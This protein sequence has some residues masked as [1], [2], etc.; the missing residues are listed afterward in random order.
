[1]I[2]ERIKKEMA[3]YAIVAWKLARAEVFEFV[4][5][6]ICIFMQL[7]DLPSFKDNPLAKSSYAEA[8]CQRAYEDL[9]YIFDVDSLEVT[10]LPE[11]EAQS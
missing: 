2:D 10:V 9:S 8:V 1:M 6:T 3:D 5:G 11:E 4:P 7:S